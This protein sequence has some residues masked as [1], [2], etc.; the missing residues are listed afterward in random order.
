[1]WI[2]THRG[3]TSDTFLSTCSWSGLSF[4]RSST[5]W[6]C[7]W[8]WF[9]SGGSVRPEPAAG[10]KAGQ[11]G[12][13]QE[14]QLFVVSELLQAEFVGLFIDVAAE[15]IKF[16]LCVSAWRGALRTR[17]CSR[18]ST[19]SRPREASSTESCGAPTPP[20][21]LWW[22]DVTNETRFPFLTCCFSDSCSVCL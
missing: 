8:S 2:F 12:C 14:E 21:P 19:T 13:R 15:S 3:G 22:F 4:W 17:S 10:G 7:C 11:T 6:T 5:V 18:S 1:M 16:V 20:P 9:C